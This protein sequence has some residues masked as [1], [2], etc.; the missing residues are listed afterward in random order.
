MQNKTCAIF[1]ALLSFAVMASG[2][3]ERKYDRFKDVT[4]ITALIGNSPMDA[5]YRS[6][7]WDV[8]V[9]FPGEK[10][11][12]EPVVTLLLTT[13]SKM[14][15]LQTSDLM[16][17]G[18]IDGERITLGKF[19][20]I[21]VPYR[22]TVIENSELRMPFASLQKI[23]SAKVVEVKAGQLEWKFSAAGLATVREFIEL[24]ETSQPRKSSV[25]SR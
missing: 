7:K 13:S 8:V 20:P 22:G 18:I 16:L 15:L 12:K 4:T 9:S 1:L 14:G 19:A 21:A 5:E 25:G 6:V 11:P 2:Q 23:G 24:F 17:Y 3:V 10:P